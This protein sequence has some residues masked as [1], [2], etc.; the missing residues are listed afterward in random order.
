MK[1]SFCAVMI[2]ILCL[3]PVVISAETNE[4]TLAGTVSFS[5]TG[6]IYIEFLTPPKDEKTAQDNPNIPSGLQ[7]HV[8]EAEVKTKKVAFTFEH[9]PAGTYGLQAFQDVNGNGQLDFG[10][11]GPKEPW[12][13]YRNVRPLFRGPKFE[14]IAFDVKEDMTIEL[15]VK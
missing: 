10:K 8:G 7:I 15:K 13:F 14:E 11:L 12:G 3:L 9:V 6:D 2:S 1:K 4:F 5:K